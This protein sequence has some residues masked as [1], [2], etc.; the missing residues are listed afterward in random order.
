MSQNPIIWTRKANVETLQSLLSQ[1]FQKQFLQP[2][3]AVYLERPNWVDLLPPDE[4]DVALWPQGRAFCPDLE[5]R[6]FPTE[7]NFQLHLLTEQPDF[8]PADGW[9]QIQLPANQ[10]AER[11]ILLWGTHRRSL[12]SSHRLYRQATNIPDEWIE[13]RLPRPLHYPVDG[14]P[15]WV[16]ANVRDYQR[17]YI[18]LFTRLH[19]LEGV[20]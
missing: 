7:S 10:V 20:Q 3:A 15:A 4:V 6:W 8:V 17:D 1:T 2:G 9:Q 13:T 16:R 19:S 11:I 14:Q 12:P 18:T 5:L